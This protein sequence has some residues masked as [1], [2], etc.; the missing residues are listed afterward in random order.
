MRATFQK[1]KH[2]PCS[3]FEDVSLIMVQEGGLPPN[4]VYLVGLIMF[5]SETCCVKLYFPF[6][7]SSAYTL[8]V[9]HPPV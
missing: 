5:Q 7:R 9:T 1:G 6:N 3:L 2:R 4:L 8:C